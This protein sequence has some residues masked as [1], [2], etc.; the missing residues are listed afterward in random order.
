VTRCVAP[1]IC[2]FTDGGYDLVPPRPRRSRS[3]WS[4]P[5]RADV[6]SV[7]ARMPR[8]APAASG[9]RSESRIP[10]A[11]QNGSS[12]HVLSLLDSSS[13]RINEQSSG[14]LIRGFGVQVPGGAPVM[15][16]GFIVP[17][18]FYAPGLPGFSV[19]R[20]TIVTHCDDSSPESRS[21]DVPQ[22]TAPPRH[23]TRPDQRAWATRPG[24]QGYR[25]RETVMVPPASQASNLFAFRP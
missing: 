18:H 4:R 12:R 16:W 25:V 13:K 2:T 21:R 10:A 22:L 3:W 20:S 24:R 17:G 19:A 23:E 8:Y 7:V 5:V 6:C 1:G 14:L 11:G 15:T 9:I